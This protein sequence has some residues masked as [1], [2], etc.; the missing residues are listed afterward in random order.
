[1]KNKELQK[2]LETYIR[3]FY[4]LND[5]GHDRNHLDAVLYYAREINNKLDKPVD[6][7]LLLTAVYF[8]DIGTSIDRANHNVIARD[9]VLRSEILREYFTEDEIE[10]ISIAVYEHRSKI[11]KSTLVSKILSD[12]DKSDVCAIDR[13][14]YR[15]WYFGLT[16]FP[17]ITDTEERILKCHN[18]QLKKYGKNAFRFQLDESYD[19]IKKELK[20]TRKCLDDYEGLFLPYVKTMIKQGILKGE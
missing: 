7:D 19:M 3:P 12:A 1:M 2:Y 20:F 8:H 14:I 9:I 18:S 17:E 5:K 13:M 6:N 4:D 16:H 15:A 11:E 10:L